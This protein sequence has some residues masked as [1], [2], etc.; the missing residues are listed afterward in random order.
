MYIVNFT[1]LLLLVPALGISYRKI[2]NFLSNYL[3]RVFGRPS[4]IEFSP[5]PAIYAIFITWI[6]IFG[7]LGILQYEKHLPKREALNIEQAVKEH[8]EQAAID[9]EVDYGAAV[10]GNPQADITMVEFSDFECPAC[11]VLAFHLRILLLEYRDE[12]Q[13]YFMN[14]PL[15]ASI[16]D[17]SKRQI[18]KNAG[19]AARAGICA[20]HL[21]DF[22]D[23]QNEMFQNQK[24]I[25]YL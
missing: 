3:K 17:Y 19:L 24:N 13:L 6:F 14:Y 22:W 18:H 7:Y 16:N 8:F 12:V 15:D 25:S 4:T 2:G 10:T 21:G 11:R 1:I 9:I 20:Q 5:K 23:Y